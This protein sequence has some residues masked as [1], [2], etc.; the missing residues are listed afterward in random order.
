MLSYLWAL[1]GNSRTLAVAYAIEL[2]AILDMAKIIDW[3]SLLGVER[4]GKVAAII[5]VVIIVL[6]LITIKPV[7]FKPEA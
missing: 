2:L 6:R 5:G 4:G 1:A 3:S 7:S